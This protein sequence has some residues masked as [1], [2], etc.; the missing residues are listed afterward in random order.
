MKNKILFFGALGKSGL[1][2]V[3]GGETGNQRTIKML[4]SLG[5]IIIK[6]FKPYP[7]KKPKVLFYLIEI[8]VSIFAFIWKLIS[9]FNSIYKCHIS[10]FYGYL[11][12]YEFILVL[13]SKLFKKKVVYEIRGGGMELFYN[14]R[15]YLYRLFF[16]S[17]INLADSILSQGQENARLLQILLKKS[18]K[19]KYVYYPNNIEDSK[20]PEINIIKDFN[21]S[22]NLVY[23]GRFCENK[24]I[25]IIIDSF[26]KIKKEN[27][28]FNLILI[29]KFVDENYKK[30]LF[31]LIDE[32]QI[33]EDIK[34]YPP[35][36]FDEI[37]K[38]LVKSHFF[39]FPSENIREG[40]SNSLTEAMAYGLIPIS[41]DVGFSSSVINDPILILNEINSN[42]IVKIIL[43]LI[44]NEKCSFCSEKMQDRVRSLYTE[45][46]A[47][48]NLW[49]VY[50]ND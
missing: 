43:D 35:S 42:E 2:I 5:F 39:I 29:G 4:E 24:N 22:L 28:N 12:Y 38:I 49:L 40:H 46:K 10:A 25:D 23:F 45:T 21:G 30:K 20:L 50:K 13:I 27:I 1:K 6:S 48:N 9:N 44:K 3:G 31:A 7:D 19:Q 34:I 32:L 18:F 8:L 47:K 41:S 26:Y 16:K 11:I 33:N 17:T 37:S 14:Q 15:G 36:S